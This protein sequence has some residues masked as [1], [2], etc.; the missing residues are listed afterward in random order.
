MSGVDTRAPDGVSPERICLA[1]ASPRRQEI[2]TQIGVSFTVRP[3]D[4]DEGPAHGE[5]PLDLA[6][7]LAVEKLQEVQDDVAERLVLAADTVV[8]LGDQLLGKPQNREDARRMLTTLS[9]RTHA[10]VSAIALYNREEDRVFTDA[11]VTKVMFALLAEDEVEW[12][13]DSGEWKGVAGGYRIQDRAA[14]FIP[15]IHGEYS[16]VVGLPIRPLYSI[17]RQNKYLLP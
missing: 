4:I 13:L 1:S 12:Y 17:L 14:A 7:R 5:P 10:V 11:G 2:L 6:A 15:Q 3:A 8:F 16:T 9:G